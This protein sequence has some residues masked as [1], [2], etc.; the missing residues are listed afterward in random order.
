MRIHGIHLR[1]IGPFSGEPLRITL[2]TGKDPELAD[3]ALFV[4]P[5]GCG[6]STL[7]YAVAGALGGDLL[8]PGDLLRRRMRGPTA[9]AALDLGADG[10]AA[11]KAP[12][13]GRE[14]LVSNPF[15]SEHLNLTSI[16][17]SADWCGVHRAKD[18][19][20]A[21]WL[22][23][24]DPTRKVAFA[25]FAYAGGRTVDSGAVPAIKEIQ[26]NPLAKALSFDRA[27]A[28]SPFVQWLANART[29]EAF[30][31][32]KGDQQGADRQ[33]EAL[34]RVEEALKHLTGAPC[35]VAFDDQT[36]SVKL[37]Q[38]D[39]PPLDLDLLPDGLKA[40]LAWLG[41]LLQR[42]DRLKW[43]GDVPLF[44]RPFVLLLDEI[45]IHLHP[46]WQRRVLPMAQR[47]FPNAQILASTHSPFVVAS[48]RDAR[49]FTLGVKDGRADVV[50]EAD[51]QAGS[52]VSTVLRSVFS[53]NEEFDEDSQAKLAE[54]YK[55][56]N[57][58]LAGSGSVD[59]LQLLADGLA[60]L[61]VEIADI[62]AFEMRQVR[63]GRAAEPM[64]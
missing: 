57:A 63:R 14:G 46:A 41:D 24:K 21:T 62:V 48:A 1:D 42:L 39:R 43:D 51:G 45:D 32:A 4:G 61:G 44:D 6:K 8:G 49:V 33:V 34:R 52:S 55:A 35:S 10:Y 27:S 58:V 2:P 36:L 5:N 18:H 38:G 59:E 40:I 56:R 31:K 9:L 29:R 60:G 47:L 64:G 54:F 22:S 28:D 30:A 12:G 3:V 53:M 11:L 26:A 23:L 25:A 15:K 7:L 37:V 20:S 13:A 17:G 16:D 50:A 19:L